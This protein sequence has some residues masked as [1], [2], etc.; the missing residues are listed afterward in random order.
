ML[1]VDS[2][3]S[4]PT[5]RLQIQM[6]ST[7]GNSQPYLLPQRFAEGSWQQVR[8]PLKTLFTKQDGS[9]DINVL[10]NINKP[11][12]LLPEWIA[13]NDTLAGMKYTIAGEKLVLNP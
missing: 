7:V 3:G 9:I 11:L 13:E 12:S 10:G 2:Y 8:V 6:E 4:H 5:K 1:N